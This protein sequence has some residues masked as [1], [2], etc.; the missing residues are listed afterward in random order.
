MTVTGSLVFCCGCWVDGG[1]EE[2]EAVELEGG[3][4]RVCTWY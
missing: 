4:G 3:G 2:D 1:R